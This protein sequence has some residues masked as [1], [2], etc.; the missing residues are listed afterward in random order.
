MIPTSPIPLYHLISTAIQRRIEDG[1]YEPGEAMP[2][3]AELSEEFDVSRP[4]I[5]QALAELV[6]A[7]MISRRRGSGTYVLPAVQHR[8]GQRFKGS[9]GDLIAETRRTGVQDI[10]VDRNAEVP[11]RIAKILEMDEP[12]GTIVKRTRT[13]D[14]RAF[15]F[16]VNYLPEEYGRLLS[17]DELK[18]HSL[19]AL[20]QSKGVVFTMARQSVRAQLASLDLTESLGLPYSGAPVLFVERVVLGPER[21]PVELVHTWYRGDAYE[22]TATFEFGQQSEDE[23]IG[24]LA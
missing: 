15:A 23:A 7:G 12:V 9:L 11:S 10:S 4:T 8:I 6:A 17:T 1:E 16:T 20:L 24:Q 2:T 22:Y 14:G 3:E 18:S 21:R 19:M 13:M 5:R